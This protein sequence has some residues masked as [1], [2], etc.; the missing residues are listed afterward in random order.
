LHVGGSRVHESG[1]R[2]SG[3][4]KRGETAGFSETHEV[5]GLPCRVWS[6][7]EPNPEPWWS[8]LWR[9]RSPGEH[10][11]GGSAL[12]RATEPEPGTDS[13]GEQGFEAGVPVAHTASPVSSVM[14]GSGGARSRACHD[15][16]SSERG[17]PQSQAHAS[18]VLLREGRSGQRAWRR[19]ESDRELLAALR[20]RQSVTK[21]ARKQR[22]A[23]AGTAPR[24]GKA[25]EGSSRDASGMKQGREASG[26]TAH[27][28]IRKGPERAASIK[29]LNRREGQEP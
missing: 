15:G 5:Q 22:P 19:G 3:L 9:G 20:R 6:R 29:S 1:R 10:R 11:L 12:A 21:H 16:R 23:R 24:E 26:A 4:A 2:R 27:G 17:K 25:L 8:E 7:E 18:T 13:R 14:V 28:G